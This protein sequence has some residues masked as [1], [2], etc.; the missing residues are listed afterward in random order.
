[1]CYSWVE[2]PWVVECPLNEEKPAQFYIA[3]KSSPADERTRVLKYGKKFAV[4][5]RFGDIELVGPGED[6]IFFEGNNSCYRERL[7]GSYRI[8]FI[9]FASALARQVTKQALANSVYTN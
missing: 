4:F 8:R 2:Y 7:P 5:D 6:G 9:D 1:M 3:T